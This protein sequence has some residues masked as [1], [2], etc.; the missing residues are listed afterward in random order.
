M[1]DEDFYKGIL[2]AAERYDKVMAKC[3]KETFKAWR[4]FQEALT[5]AKSIHKEK[6]S[7]N[8]R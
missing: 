1:K 5:V 6:E 3:E 4:K 8:D 7:N 2:K